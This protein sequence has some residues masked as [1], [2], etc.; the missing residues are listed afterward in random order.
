MKKIFLFILSLISLVSIGQTYNPSVAGVTVNTPLAPGQAVPT[1]S[2][3]MFFDP[4]FQKWRPYVSTNEVLSYLNLTKYRVGG[5]DIIVNTGGTLSAGV[6][7]GG[8]NSVYWFRNGTSNSDLV[9]K[10]NVATVN[11]QTGAVVVGNAD[12]IRAIPVDI[13]AN[14][15]NYN[16]VYDSVN[17]R[18]YLAP[19]ASGGV[20]TQGLG[21][22][23][24]NTAKTITAQNTQALWNAAQLRGRTISANAPSLGNVI[25]WDGLQWAP[26]SGAAFDNVLYSNDTLFFIS[27]TD[28]IKTQFIVS[29]PGDDWGFQTAATQS[30]L[31][32]N[33][34]DETPISADTTSATGLA[35]KHDITVLQTEIDNIEPGGGGGG[36][37]TTR[38]FNTALPDSLSRKINDSTYRI[39]S[40]IP[41]ANVTLSLQGDTAIVIGSTPGTAEVNTNG[42]TLATT[43]NRTVPVE[44]IID[45]I[46]VK[47]TANL[48]AFKVG[49]AGD[50]DAFITSMP[51]GADGT[52]RTIVAP[53]YIASSTAIY[54]S[55]IT[56][57]T[58]IQLVFKPLH[59]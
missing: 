5:F 34:L 33:G 40:L 3:S 18:F 9:L 15:N 44:S 26:S 47:P 52:Y 13:S 7:T 36:G 41:G 24:D 54:F 48:T 21:I 58:D 2:R 29:V 27:G 43:G 31:F 17:A 1:D 10:G 39:L 22:T 59:R 56:S 57:S 25:K 51:V 16:L 53:F 38:L 37:P 28:T 23:I 32:G 20:Y 14:R 19:P 49:T 6:I 50:D 55:G 42:F 4:S 30:P 35:T 46:L 45:Y 8:T 11:G 12:S